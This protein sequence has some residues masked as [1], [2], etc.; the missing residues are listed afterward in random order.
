MPTQRPVVGWFSIPTVQRRARLL[1]VERQ[2]VQQGARRGGEAAGDLQDELYARRLLAAFYSRVVRPV[3][4][5]VS[6]RGLL[7][8]AE[9]DPARL[10][11]CA[12]LGEGG[13]L[14]WLRGSSRA[15]D[16]ATKAALSSCNQSDYCYRDVN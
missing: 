13:I 15:H 14:R 8:Q 6:G 11:S 5:C 3:N 12:E 2:P 1:V 4:P 16:E 10:H 7:G 9:L